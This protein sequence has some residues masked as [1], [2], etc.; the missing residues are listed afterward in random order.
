MRAGGERCLNTR[1]GTGSSPLAYQQAQ[2]TAN[3]VVQPPFIAL[4]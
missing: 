3:A 4:D 2:V 1:F